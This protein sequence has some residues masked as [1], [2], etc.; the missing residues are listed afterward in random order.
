VSH[1]TTFEVPKQERELE[2]WHN[3]GIPSREKSRPTLSHLLDTLA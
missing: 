3:A 2:L 1:T